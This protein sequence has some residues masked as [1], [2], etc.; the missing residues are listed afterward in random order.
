MNVGKVIN[1]K[2][3]AVLLIGDTHLPYEHKDYLKFC[4]AVKEKYNCTIYVHVGDEVDNHAISFHDS[5]CELPSAGDELERAITRLGGWEDA[6][7][8]LI[9]LDSNHGS[10]AVRR[11]KHHGIP[12]AYIKPLKEVYR[13]PTWTW[14]EDIL[15]DTKAGYVYGCHGKSKA[16]H[17]LAD[18][19]GCSCFQG[20]YHGELGYKWQES[21]LGYRF[22]MFVGC[23]IDRVSLAF[24]Y[25][26][27]NIPK[28]ML[29]CGVIDKEGMPHTVRMNLN[30]KGRWDGKV[31]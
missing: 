23:G 19:Q 31:S 29:G 5:D 9:L 10:L 28:P 13:T 22:N 24:A 12:L 8:G 4:K 17:A 7:P 18:K 3:K 1:A 15:I 26:R 25:G 14:T 27:N 2:N 21:S 6:F 30:K 20:H 16:Q 11:F